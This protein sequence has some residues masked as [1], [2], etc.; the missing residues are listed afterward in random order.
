MLSVLIQE[1]AKREGIAI[2]PKSMAIVK[3][4]VCTFVE[5]CKAIQKEGAHLTVVVN[6][7]DK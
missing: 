3:R 4:G 5:K 7:E 1:A 6:T 2:V